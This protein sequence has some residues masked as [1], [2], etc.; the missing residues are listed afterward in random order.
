MMNQIGDNEERNP[1]YASEATKRELSPGRQNM[2]HGRVQITI[3]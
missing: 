2:Q 1:L 3:N